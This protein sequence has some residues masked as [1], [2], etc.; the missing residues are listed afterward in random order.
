[1]TRTGIPVPEIGAGEL[2][3]PRSSRLP[4]PGLRE[5]WIGRVRAV[6]RIYPADR[7]TPKRAGTSAVPWP[8]P[9]S[10]TASIRSPALTTSQPLTEATGPQRDARAGTAGHA[11]R[12]P[13][14]TPTSG[15]VVLGVDIVPQVGW[16]FEVRCEV[17]IPPRRRSRPDRHIHRHSQSRAIAGPLPF[18]YG[19]KTLT[20]P[21]ATPSCSSEVLTR[22]PLGDDPPDRRDERSLA[23]RATA[24]VDGT[25][26]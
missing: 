20:S 19:A 22:S 7:V 26:S 13:H 18:G 4:A 10:G 5:P 8:K 25:S 17:R 12:A 3:G 9:Q 21:W 15:S 2:A 16:P 1:M 11:G 14:T 23:H 6:G 24:V